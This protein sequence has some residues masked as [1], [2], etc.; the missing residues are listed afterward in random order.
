[1]K[2]AI[3]PIK[4]LVVEDEMDSRD[5]LATFLKLSGY[6]VSTANDGLE[7]LKK[8]KAEHPDIIISDICMP[9]LDGIEMVKTLRNSSEFRAIPIIM[10]TALGSENLISGMNAGANEAMRKP[11]NPDALLKHIKDWLAKPKILN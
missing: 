4:I 1:V 9:I 2:E 10:M 8:A 3:M 5:F 11:I 7:A 6:S